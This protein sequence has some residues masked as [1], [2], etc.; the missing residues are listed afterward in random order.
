MK[1]FTTLFIVLALLGSGTALAKGKI[2][3]EDVKSVAEVVA[4]G[5]TAAQTIN[6]TKIY[7]T[8]NGLNKQ[9]S[10]AIT[11]GDF[12]G[13]G[14][15]QPFDVT[16]LG[17][18]GTVSSNALTLNL[19][20]ADASSAP[21]SGTGAV[22]ASFRNAT[23]TT[24]GYTSVSVTGALSITAPNGASFGTISGQNQ[25]IFVYLINNAGTA[26][27]AMAGDAA[28]DEG[29]T[30]NTTAI[31]GS[32]TARNVLYSTTARTGVAVRLVARVQ[33]SETTA[34]TYASAP[35]EISV[36]PLGVNRK[37]RSEV[38]VNTCTAHGSTNL[39]VIRF[40]TTQITRGSAI[41]YTDSAT[42]GGTFQVKE[43]GV[44]CMSL[45]N[46][47]KDGTRGP[48]GAIDRN[49]TNLSSDPSTIPNSERIAVFENSSN[50]ISGSINSTS[51]CEVLDTNDFIYAMSIQA[52]NPTISA[53]CIFT[54]TK[55]TE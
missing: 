21:A 48:T 22:K 18:T 40:N 25:Y 14:A 55:V 36:L 19:K 1:K 53:N 20:Q 17:L 26:E 3:N 27:L 2:Q 34:G 32:S 6:D 50:P 5:G 47:N 54:I 13:T 49:G 7:V 37:A 29:T 52:D 42:L 46:G 43:P 4:A 33:V 44:Y 35:S 28:F 11:A 9:L 8:A 15:N 30:Y 23:L 45:S 31:S 16:N 51:V 24:G 39:S 10:A 41:V 12:S 38:S